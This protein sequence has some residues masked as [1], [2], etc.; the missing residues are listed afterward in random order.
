MVPAVNCSVPGAQKLPGDEN[1]D[2]LIT[3]RMTVGGGVC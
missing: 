1:F 3:H 2:G